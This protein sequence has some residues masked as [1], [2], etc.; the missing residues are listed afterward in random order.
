M[1][2]GPW[3][4]EENDL[5]VADYFAMLADD[6]FARRYSKAEHRRALLPRL[7]DRSEGSVEFKH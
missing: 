7:N 2:N 5:I 4:D 1:S 3:T 6:I